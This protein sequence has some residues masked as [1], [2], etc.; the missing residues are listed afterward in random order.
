MCHSTGKGGRY[1]VT[2]FHEGLDVESRPSVPA[3]A[4]V[5]NVVTLTRVTTGKVTA[6]RSPHG[7]QL[8]DLARH[9]LD[10]PAAIVRTRSS[11]VRRTTDPANSAAPSW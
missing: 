6:G 10:H 5:L 3:E 9:G 8:D 1:A 4:P 7:L 11:P 2:G